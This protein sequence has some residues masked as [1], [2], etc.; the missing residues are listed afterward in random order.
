VSLVEVLGYVASLLI[1]AS[2]SMTSV[3]RLRALSLLG[4]VAY[5]VYG[6]LIGA[7]PVVLANAVIAGLNIHFL[8]KEIRTRKDLGAVPIGV[9]EPFLAD[10]LAAT[11][12]DARRFQPNAD[13]AG[14]DSAWLLMRDGLPVGAVVGRRTGDELAVEIDYVTPAYRDSQLG[15]W[16]YGAGSGVLRKAGIRRVVADKGTADHTSYLAG[17]GFVERDGRMVRDLG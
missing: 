14:A 2:L 16:L 9:D 7:Y 13:V 6:L 17:V 15:R 8:L 5:V 10:Y 4:S 3:V 11:S 1:V 12:S